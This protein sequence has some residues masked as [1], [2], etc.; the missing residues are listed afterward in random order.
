MTCD[1]LV[2]VANGVS[3][4]MLAAFVTFAH[5]MGREND[6]LRDSNKDIMDR[7]MSRDYGEYQALERARGPQG[8]TPAA[9]S[10]WTT[11]EEE[12]SLY[13]QSLGA[14]LPPNF[15]ATWMDKD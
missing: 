13:L 4:L 10:E 5:R 6:A 3:L 12:S 9:E 1:L 15:N 2:W 7:F 11:S 14:E 8:D